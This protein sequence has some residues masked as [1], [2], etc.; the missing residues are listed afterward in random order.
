ML[1]LTEEISVVW[2]EVGDGTE[3]DGDCE[4]GKHKARSKP[5]GDLVLISSSANDG[6][7]PS[8]GYLI[9]ARNAYGGS[10]RSI[11]SVADVI[12]EMKKYFEDHNSQPFSLLI[13]DHGTIAKMS[14]GDGDITLGGKYIDDR[15]ATKADRDAFM[16]ACKDYKVT[17][18]TLAGCCVATD[19]RGRDFVA[20]AG[21]W[22]SVY[23]QGAKQE[24]RFWQKRILFCRRGNA[25]DH[26]V[27]AIAALNDHFGVQKWKNRRKSSLV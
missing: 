16:K 3:K 26:E 27:A 5:T 25:V 11:S 7:N 2:Y 4:D 6:P 1:E 15:A 20:I 9:R 24:N 8:S 18:C 10:H 22:W 13:I 12:A 23:D 19:K 17:T 21:A 14:M